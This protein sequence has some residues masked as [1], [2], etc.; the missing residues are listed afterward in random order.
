MRFIAPDEYTIDASIVDQVGQSFG[1]K[2][3]MSAGISK[4]LVIS[5]PTPETLVPV[6]TSYCPFKEIAGHY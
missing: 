6:T 2:S 1:I 4:L 3:G 5:D